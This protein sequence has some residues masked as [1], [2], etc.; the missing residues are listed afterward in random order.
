[1]ICTASRLPHP[2][3]LAGR[4]PFLP[5]RDFDV[6]AHIGSS[7]FQRRSRLRACLAAARLST[8][9][10]SAP[11]Q[12]HPVAP[13]G[14]PASSRGVGLPRTVTRPEPALRPSTDI[15]AARLL[16]VAGATFGLEA[17]SSE[18]LFRPR[19]FSPPRRF[20]P[21][22]GS[23]VC[24]TLQPVLGFAAFCIVKSVS[25]FDDAPRW[26]NHPSKDTT[27]LTA[28]T[29]SLVPV[30][31]LTFFLGF[32][33]GHHRWWTGTSPRP[34]PSRPCSVRR[35]QVGRHVAMAYPPCSFLG[36]SPLRGSVATV[37]R[38]PVLSPGWEDRKRPPPLTGRT[39][40]GWRRAGCVAAERAVS[41]E[42]PRPP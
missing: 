41:G 8:L 38:S 12:S 9:L 23:Q 10:V 11:L 34:S 17:T 26:R 30:A 5:C 37:L 28:V 16:P 33:P 4:W 1:V 22:D 14:K 36:F 24:C 40:V 35:L 13:A 27:N 39:R 25:Q 6:L 31:S 42:N 19:G 2:R 20:S 21:R 15:S 29:R 32:E 18:V 7:A 3:R